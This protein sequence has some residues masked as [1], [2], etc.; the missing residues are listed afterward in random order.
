M[1]RSFLSVPACE[2]AMIWT[3]L[4]LDSGLS[5]RK[6][7]LLKLHLRICTGCT[8]FH[9]QMAWLNSAIRALFVHGIEAMGNQQIRLSPERKEEIQRRI[10]AHL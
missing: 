9:K 3:S 1:K 4:Q 2:E 6:R 8:N 5:L 7:L 10:Q